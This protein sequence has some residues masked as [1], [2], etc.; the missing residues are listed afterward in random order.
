MTLAPWRQ[1]GAVFGPVNLVPAACRK[2]QH[3]H[4]DI[5]TLKTLT[6]GFPGQDEELRNLNQNSALHLS[7]NFLVQLPTL[8]L[9]DCGD[10]DIFVLAANNKVKIV[11]KKEEKFKA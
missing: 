6:L 8:I 4:M 10:P 7:N 11:K 3:Q 9:L 5:N 1:G 2:H